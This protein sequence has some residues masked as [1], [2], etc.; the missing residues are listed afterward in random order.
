MAAA[1]DD[2]VVMVQANDEA[3]PDGRVELLSNV[4]VNASLIERI[5]SVDAAIVS[6][7]IHRADP[8]LGQQTIHLNDF[9]HIDEQED[10]DEDG[11]FKV[12]ALGSA[13][14][15]R[16]PNHWPAPWD[17]D[18]SV[19][20][21]DNLVKLRLR[22]CGSVPWNALARLTKLEELEFGIID[23]RTVTSSIQENL[24]LPS[25][26]H[27]NIEQSWIA[28]RGNDD[29][30]A[31]V[32]GRLTFH[33]PNLMTLRF[34]SL[35]EDEVPCILQG[36]ANVIPGAAI[37]NS[38]VS[39]KFFSCHVQN[40]HLETILFD[41]LPVYPNLDD[42]FLGGSDITSLQ[43]VA[44]RLRIENLDSLPSP[45]LASRLTLCGLHLH[46][47]PF[48][49]ELQT[50]AEFR[51]AA[52]TLLDAFPR[53][54][55]LGMVGRSEM[56]SEIQ[57]KLRINFAGR[58]LLGEGPSKF[59]RPI[60]LSVWPYVL[61]R[62]MFSHLEMVMT[63]VPQICM[64]TEESGL[65]YLLRHG[66]ALAGRDSFDPPSG[67]A[68]TDNSAPTKTSSQ[69]RPRIKL[70]SGQNLVYPPGYM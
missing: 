6:L 1:G 70:L 68:S 45:V 51:T 24:Q 49:R 23:M 63:T 31:Q 59:L 25:I 57:F 17:L 7:L 53:L 54:R 48:I 69:N 33:F 20:R 13:D 64:I 28:S 37:K 10:L 3:N 61:E 36:L 19:A 56:P 52:M 62:S 26:K 2:D 65:Y 44:E 27:I 18:R 5:D 11:R 15:D 30:R 47:S 4:T 32:M 39:L 34:C 41:V 60:P 50:N 43:R 46:A 40:A 12:L 16:F 14:F 67:T 66:G 35:G 8:Q 42:V 22:G 9:V 21:L 58:V 38:L 29:A 55:T